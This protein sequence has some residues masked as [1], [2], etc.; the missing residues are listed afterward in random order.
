M[1][2]LEGVGEGG[3]KFENLEIC[4]GVGVGVGANM[5]P[6]IPGPFIPH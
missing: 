1:C 5:S 3:E 4:C 2:V 6:I